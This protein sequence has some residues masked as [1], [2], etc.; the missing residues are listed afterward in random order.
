ML[1]PKIRL[2]D[3]LI[4][5][6]QSGR[7]A[8]GISATDLSKLIGKALSYVSAL[9]NRRIAKVASPDLVKIFS[10]LQNCS[11]D[12]AAEAIENLLKENETFNRQTTTDVWEDDAVAKK[13]SVIKT[14]SLDDNNVPEETLKK[15]IDAINTR[16]RAFYKVHPNDALGILQNFI[17]SMNFDLGF[18]MAILSTPFFRL[19][20]YNHEERQEVYNEFIGLFKKHFAEAQARIAEET[21]EEESVADE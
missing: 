20:P 21:P 12:D 7:Q 1:S 19:K 6:I 9:E 16:I 4:E 18:V 3:E 11:E 14:Y 15:Y 17:R 13:P 10:I 5:K 8:K 2:N